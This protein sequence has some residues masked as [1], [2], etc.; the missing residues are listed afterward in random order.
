MVDMFILANTQV[1]AFLLTISILLMSAASAA[2]VLA[3]R[4]VSTKTTEL[5]E[6]SSRQ[7][8]VRDQVAAVR[9]RLE[10][11]TFAN[12]QPTDPISGVID[13]FH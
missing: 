12:R 1:A 10:H 3:V 11:T 5:V 13:S 6:A 9:R 8:D 7:A 4:R 2:A